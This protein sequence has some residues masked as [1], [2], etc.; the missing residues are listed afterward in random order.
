V[1]RSGLEAPYLVLSGA[2]EELA[3]RAGVGHWH[4]SLTHTDQVAMASVLAERDGSGG[5]QAPAGDGA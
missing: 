2:A 5:T 3:R 1:V 4:L